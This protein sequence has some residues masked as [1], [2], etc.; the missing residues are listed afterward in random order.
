MEELI[1]YGNG[2]IA[3]VMYY[4]FSN[5]SNYR[6]I[7]F[8]CEQ[9]YITSPSFNGLPVIPFEEVEKSHLPSKFKMFIA[10]GFLEMNDIRANK[11]MEAKKKGYSIVNYIHPL[12]DIPVNVEYGEN[13][14]IMNNTIILPKVKIG[15]N[16]FV[17]QGTVIGHHSVIGDNCWFSSPTIISGKVTMGKNCFLGANATLGHNI[18][19]G[20]Y[21]FL[22]ANVLQV[23][24][25]GAEK[26]V[27]AEPS[28]AL[29]ISSKEFSKIFKF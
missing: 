14:I 15:S 27:I 9:K 17:W 5:A 19:I 2:D 20:D 21:C 24:N 7:A 6:V 18:S 10:L 29:D 1:L 4:Y 13:T 16:V 23:K 28:S 8:T 25:L 22:G 11:Y 3:E 12:A 26:V